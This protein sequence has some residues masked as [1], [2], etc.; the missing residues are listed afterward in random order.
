[1][2]WAATNTQM[3]GTENKIANAGNMEEMRK[4]M[5]EGMKKENI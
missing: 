5:E 3:Q 1:M 2:G 4:R